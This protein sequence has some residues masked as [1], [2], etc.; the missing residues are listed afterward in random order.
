MGERDVPRTTRARTGLA[1]FGAIF[2]F[3]DRNGPPE[4]HRADGEVVDDD[5]VRADGGEED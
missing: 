3:G 1:L 5:G 4:A 2:G